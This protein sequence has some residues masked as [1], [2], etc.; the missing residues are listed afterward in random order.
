M[1]RFTHCLSKLTE[2][3]CILAFDANQFDQNPFNLKSNALAQPGVTE[4]T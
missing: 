4:T 2:E 3:V 1:F